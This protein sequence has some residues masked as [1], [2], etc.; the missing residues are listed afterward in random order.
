MM[1][2]RPPPVTWEVKGNLQRGRMEVP[3][4]MTQL[5]KVIHDII[6]Y[7]QKRIPF[8]LGTT[9]HPYLPGD[10]VWVKDWKQQTLPPPG[11]HH[12]QLY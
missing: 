2:G 4:Q 6:P 5:G 8:S 9:V 3:W 10:L 11:K 1:F 7:V 12:T